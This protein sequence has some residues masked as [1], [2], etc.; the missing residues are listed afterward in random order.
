MKFSYRGFS[1][2][3][4]EKDFELWIAEW[5]IERTV[6]SSKGQRLD[7]M[8]LPGECPFC[9]VYRKRKSRFEYDC[10]K[11]PLSM[12]GVN[13][14]DKKIDGC[15]N[16]LISILGDP[17]GNPAATWGFIITPNEKYILGEKGMG[18]INKIRALIE[19]SIV[20]GGDNDETPK[21]F[22]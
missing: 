5:D 3:L 22:C 7:I 4:S 16:L 9:K 13:D 1:F 18:N 12:Y 19:N 20:D 14:G 10:R 2:E 6:A 11:C 17:G 8:K 21:R 15:V